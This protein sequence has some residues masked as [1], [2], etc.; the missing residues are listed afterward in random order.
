MYA[1]PKVLPINE[2]KNTAKISQVC[3]DSSSP[4]IVTKNGY[5]DMVIMSVEMYE[6]L[7]A[8]LQVASKVNAGIDELQ[9]GSSTVSA[10]NFMKG[11]AGQ[12][13]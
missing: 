2:L 13:E 7:F 11:L 12:Y 5:S 10:K 1:L 8:K 6:E 3:K 9:N 4:I